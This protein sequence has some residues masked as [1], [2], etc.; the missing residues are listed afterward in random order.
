MLK[1]GF[2][3]VGGEV[4]T[5]AGAAGKFS[6]S[7]FLICVAQPCIESQIQSQW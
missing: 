2:L 6:A 4:T 1:Y 5:I 7:E 3:K